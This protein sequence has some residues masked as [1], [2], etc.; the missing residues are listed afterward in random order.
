MSR[1]NDSVSSAINRR[2]ALAGGCSAGLASW[3]GG[4][5]ASWAQ[6][7]EPEPHALVSVGPAEIA[8]V[9]DVQ[10]VIARLPHDG[11][12]LRFLPG[13]YDIAWSGPVF[14]FSGF[15]NLTIDANGAEFRF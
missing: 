9:A 14:R 6:A 5:R 15:R 12:V 8:T 11:G 4:R 7:R 3:L 13:R 10:S 2:R 1:L